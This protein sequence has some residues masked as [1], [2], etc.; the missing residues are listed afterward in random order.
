M[1]YDKLVTWCGSE[2][3][4]YFFS[5][6]FDYRNMSEPEM[7]NAVVALLVRINRKWTGEEESRS[8]RLNTWADTGETRSDDH[9]R[10]Y[11]PSRLPVRVLHEEPR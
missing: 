9:I 10:M 2:G 4:A 6:Q 1:T 5:T 11:E 8:S 7:Q 3:Q